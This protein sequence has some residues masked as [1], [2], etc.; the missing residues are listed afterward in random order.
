MSFFSYFN[1]S[2]LIRFAPHI[3]FVV[4]YYYYLQLVEETT[5]NVTRSQRACPN[6]TAKRDRANEQKKPKLANST[7]Q[8]INTSVMLSLFSLGWLCVCGVYWE[9][10]IFA[11]L[12]E[13]T[14]Q[15][16][17]WNTKPMERSRQKRRKKNGNIITI[18]IFIMIV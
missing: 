14:D 11:L 17:V 9:F 6:T 7:P 13:K 4:T 18:W 10:A 3:R 16:R 1:Q 8:E 2:R 15:D 5:T 12:M